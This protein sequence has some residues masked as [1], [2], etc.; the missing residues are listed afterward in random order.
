M[1]FGV[2]PGQRGADWLTDMTS[3]QGSGLEPVHQR[4]GGGSFN[5]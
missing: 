5:R 1:T 2:T 3:E 4:V